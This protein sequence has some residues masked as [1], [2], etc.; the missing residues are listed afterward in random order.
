MTTIYKEFENNSEVMDVLF[1]IIDGKKDVKSIIKTLKQP[2]STISTKLQFLRENHVVVKQKWNYDIN[3]NMLNKVFLRELR[4]QMRMWLK[5]ET[6][7]NKFM[8][9]FNE[10]RIKSILKEYATLCIIKGKTRNTSMEYITN[11]YFHGLAETDDKELRKIDKRFI[12][13]KRL[14]GVEAFEWALF[15]NSEYNM[16]KKNKR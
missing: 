12:K 6:K 5:D 16:N 10:N 15:F 4:N 13:L 9:L 8:V 11:D 3:W 14:F 7:I 1:C 2:Q